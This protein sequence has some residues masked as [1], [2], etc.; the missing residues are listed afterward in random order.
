MSLSIIHGCIAF[1]NGGLLFKSK[2]KCLAARSIPFD[3]PKTDKTIKAKAYPFKS[4][5]LVFSI[6]ATAKFAKKQTGNVSFRYLQN[7]KM[8]DVQTTSRI[9][10]IVVT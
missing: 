7:L 2:E 6:N 9:N 4:A 8:A 3:S 10:W 1:S 5:Q